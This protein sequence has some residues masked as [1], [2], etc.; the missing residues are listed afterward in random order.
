MKN[1]KANLQW[2]EYAKYKN[3][4]STFVQMTTKKNNVKH[5]KCKI[6]KRSAKLKDIERN[7]KWNTFWLCCCEMSI[8]RSLTST[9]GASKSTLK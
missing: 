1:S 9:K 4:L 5:I 3:Q 8:A 7:K 2:N 6:S